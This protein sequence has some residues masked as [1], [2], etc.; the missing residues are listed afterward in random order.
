MLFGLSATSARTGM[1]LAQQLDV[2]VCVP[3][4]VA[5]SVRQAQ[6]PFRTALQ[7]LS[8]M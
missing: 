5:A 2:P 7:R 8:L 1:L 4:G 3:L 6:R